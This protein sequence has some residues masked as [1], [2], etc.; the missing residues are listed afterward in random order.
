M[1][2][3]TEVQTE[4]QRL[5]LIVENAEGIDREDCPE[6]TA[7][8]EALEWVLELK[9]EVGHTIKLDIMIL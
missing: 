2:M 9:D 7:K 1:K 5:Q 3:I 8:I 6:L 4:L